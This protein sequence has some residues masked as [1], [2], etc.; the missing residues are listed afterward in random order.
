M[1]KTKL[2]LYVDKNISE[3]AKI[4]SDISGKSISAMVSEYF[5]YKEE[6]FLKHKISE[7][8]TKWIGIA[9]TDKTYKELR[10]ESISDKITK[11]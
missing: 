1:V 8:T 11:A 2:T 5:N 7:S 6:E 9:K 4:I 3:K 10:D